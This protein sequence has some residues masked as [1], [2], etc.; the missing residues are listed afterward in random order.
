MR[1]YFLLPPQRWRAWR[2]LH[3]WF[4]LVYTITNLPH[5]IADILVPDSRLDQRQG[6]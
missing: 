3:F 2:R 5:L 1:A 6:R 4:S